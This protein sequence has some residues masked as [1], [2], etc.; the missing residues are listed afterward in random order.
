[1]FEFWYANML[2]DYDVDHPMIFSHWLIICLHVLL[3]L[4]H[5]Y[6]RVLIYKSFYRASTCLH[7][8]VNND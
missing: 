1:M 6:Y 7:G 2:I 5:W 3:C 8:H 4:W